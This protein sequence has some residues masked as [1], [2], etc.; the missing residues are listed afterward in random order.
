[1]KKSQRR[2]GKP[3]LRASQGQAQTRPQQSIGWDAACDLVDWM[4]LTLKAKG[5]NIPDMSKATGIS[6]ATIKSWKARKRLPS[7][8][9][10]ANC[11][12]Y[13]GR[14][15]LPMPGIVAVKDGVNFYPIQ[16][17]RDKLRADRLA[18]NAASRGLKEEEYL[19][20]ANEL[21]KRAIEAELYAR[22]QM[23]EQDDDDEDLSHMVRLAR[24]PGRRIR[25][26]WN[27]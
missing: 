22:S 2:N 16:A 25:L 1:M 12:G 17:F 3:N 9:S 6:V 8:E 11:A 20:S 27:G 26:Y 24:V 18:A 4:F 15:I 10:M 14:E 7:L 5:L 23:P 21:A 19:P 13:L